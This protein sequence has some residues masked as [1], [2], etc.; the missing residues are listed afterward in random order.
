MDIST[1]QVPVSELKV[2]G[3]SPDSSVNLSRESLMASSGCSTPYHDR[4]DTN[5]DFLSTTEETNLELSYETE[6]EKAL[7]VSMA[8]NHQENTRPLHVHN[9]V[10]LTYAPH[11]ED[12]INI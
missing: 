8:A 7:R 1:G 5:M 11:E 4:M 10:S 3:R 9:E 6:Q 12:V 2:R